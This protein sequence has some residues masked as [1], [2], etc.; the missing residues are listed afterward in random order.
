MFETTDACFSLCACR[1]GLSTKSA[2]SADAAAIPEASM[3]T[4]C[5]LPVAAV[6]TL[7]NGT[8]KAAVP[9]AV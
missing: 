3:K 9:F 6:I 2:S 1:I 5:Q 8:S 7:L 4:A